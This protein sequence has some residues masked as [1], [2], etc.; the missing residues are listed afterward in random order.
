LNT[1]AGGGGGPGGGGAFD[2]SV[3]NKTF[4]QSFL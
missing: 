4:F 1:G 2:I 3:V